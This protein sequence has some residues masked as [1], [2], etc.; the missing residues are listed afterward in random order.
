MTGIGDYFVIVP[1]IRGGGVFTSLS[2]ATNGTAFDGVPFFVVLRGN[3][4]LLQNNLRRSKNK[5]ILLV[6]KLKPC[7]II[8]V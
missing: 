5:S 2:W 6:D 1:V 3:P 4:K 7:G 8:R